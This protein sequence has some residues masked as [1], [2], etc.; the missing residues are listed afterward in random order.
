M[1][2]FDFLLVRLIIKTD[3]SKHMILTKGYFSIQYK[4]G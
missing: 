1:A 3:F 4:Q 2:F